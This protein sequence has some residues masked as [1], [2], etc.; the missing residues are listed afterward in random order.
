M[1]YGAKGEQVEQGSSR[2]F[3]YDDPVCEKSIRIPQRIQKS[4]ATKIENL[5]HVYMVASMESTSLVELA[6]SSADRY[7]IR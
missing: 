6:D 5:D 1:R 7:S 2:E 4:E 3:T